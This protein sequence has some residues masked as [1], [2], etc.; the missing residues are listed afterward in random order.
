MSYLL[1]SQEMK[2]CDKNTIE[3]YGIPSAV[4]MERA[5][6]SVVEEIRRRFLSRSNRIL[7]VCGAG[8]NGGDG[9]AIGRLLWLLGYDVKIFFPMDEAK[10]TSDTK[11]Q[12]DIVLKYQIPVLKEMEDFSCDILVDALF[13]IGL[14]REIQGR[15]KDILNKINAVLAYKVAVDIPSGIS[16][17]DGTI[18]GTAF[19]A[20]LTVTFGF[21]KIGQIL[22]P[23]AEYCGKLLVADIGINDKSFLEA[24]P[25]GRILD[26]ET[27][28][29]LLPKRK[30]YS[31]KGSYGKVL[32]IAGSPKMAGAAYLSAKA[33]YYS[34][35]GLVRILTA[36]EN[37]EI[38]LGRL[39]EA[40]V[41]TYDAKQ[42]D[43][44]Q[45]A[46]CIEWADA[47][48]IGPGLGTDE[49]AKQLVTYVAKKSEL[50]VVFDADALNVLAKDMELL[51]TSDCKKIVT[52]HLGEMS[53]MRNMDI[54]KIQK[55]LIPV[56]RDFAKEYG[57]VCILKDARTVT[58]QPDGRFYINA[59]G[60][61]GMATGGSG[62]V[63]AGLTVGLLAQGLDAE[64]AAPLSC[65][66]HGAAGD[67]AARNNGTYSMLAGDI[68]EQIPT[69]ICQCITGGKNEGIQ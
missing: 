62:D 65:Y 10:M 60:N 2:E 12:Y 68:L 25:F 15:L 69:A 50:P 63:L 54:E 19:R 67:L 66:L 48:L 40:I 42:P 32:I 43:M 27:A 38:L 14:S 9:F 28:K 47:V 37:R 45:V 36:E 64:I 11:A 3:Y 20:D 26:Q 34:G 52:P 53:R 29:A 16:T 41:T 23:G 4:L 58:G 49:T 21:A 30:P 7:V 31:N 17:D 44:E 5:A 55:Q 59:T 51:K 57:T 39:P 33:A 22:Y 61:H 6:L 46:G 18:M 13:G 56:A 8:N 1:N 24:E 35:S